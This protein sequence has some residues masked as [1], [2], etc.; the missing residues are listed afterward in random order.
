MVDRRRGS[1]LY[2]II[3]GQRKDII[4]DATRLALD[5]AALVYRQALQSRM[6][7]YSRMKKTKL[8]VPVISVGN[9]T[10]G[11]T[12]KTPVCRYLSAMLEAAGL[13][14]GVATR[15]YGREG[16]GT[17]LLFSGSGVADWHHCGDEAVLYL[18]GARDVVVAVDPDR[19]R[20]ATILEKEHGRDAILLDDGFQFVTLERDVNIAVIDSKAPFGYDK[21]I[22][23][24][25]LREPVS[26]LKRAD[27]FW[28]AKADAMD[29]DDKKAA[30]RRLALEFPGKPIV[31]SVYEPTGLRAMFRD[32]A[33]EPIE[34]LTGKKALCFSGIG[35]PEP[36]EALVGR[37]SGAKTI[38]YRFTD[39]HP[40]GDKD[41]S[42]A[43]DEALLRGA[44][45]IV[46][47]EKDAVRTPK[48]FKP[49]CEWRSLEI[50]VKITEI[51]G[52]TDGLA[53]MDRLWAK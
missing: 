36:F 48:T 31:E 25:L 29:A 51:H 14:V 13:K 12:G 50:S 19:S 5:G 44:D 16:T 40:F 30:L 46:T 39:H 7:K 43:E 23:A 10:L 2:P 28:I 27:M 35:T 33:V 6:R 21:L 53:L 20:A 3:S 47:T 1:E 32:G 26:S 38:P 15:G 8:G 52:S 42:D 17:G 18:S 34:T 22:P 11:G 4:A 41:L 45:Y 37:I 9:I 49:K 24:G